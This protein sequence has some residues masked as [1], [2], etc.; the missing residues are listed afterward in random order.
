MGGGNTKLLTEDADSWRGKRGVTD[1]ER[2]VMDLIERLQDADVLGQLDYQCWTPDADWNAE[3]FGEGLHRPHAQQLFCVVQSSM[4]N[5]FLRAGVRLDASEC[6]LKNYVLG[7]FTH[8]V[9]RCLIAT[10]GEIVTPQYEGLV[11]TALADVCFPKYDRVAIS[12]FLARCFAMPDNPIALSNEAIQ[13]TLSEQLATHII[14]VVRHINIDTFIYAACCAYQRRELHAGHP[15]QQVVCI[16]RSL[17]NVSLLL[18]NTNEEIKDG[19]DAP[20]VECVETFNCS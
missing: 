9:M 6:Y 16:R 18:T 10:K 11:E 3:P 4:S 17:A 1:I 13:A 5:G 2:I 19:S 20:E 8:H 15:R 14:E 12:S 7:Y